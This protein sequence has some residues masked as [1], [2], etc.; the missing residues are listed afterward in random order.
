[1]KEEEFNLCEPSG[2]ANSEARNLMK[3]FAVPESCP[4]PDKELCANDHKID[5]TK[6]KNF[7]SLAKGSIQ[8]DATIEHDT[9]KSCLHVELEISK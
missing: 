5:I 7:L 6:Y 3:V 2:W 8:I 4:V 9:G 1:M